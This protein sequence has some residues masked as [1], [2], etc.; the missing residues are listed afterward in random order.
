MLG[1]I[2]W[3]DVQAD[4][5]SR[6]SE[7]GTPEGAGQPAP[8]PTI[9]MASLS[10][11]ARSVTLSLNSA[12]AKTM[13]VKSI[14]T[15]KAAATKKTTAKK[16]TKKTTAKKKTTTKK[17]TTAK[18]KKTT[19]KKKTT[20]RKAVIKKVA[21][22]KSAAKK[23]VKIKT[24]RDEDPKV[25][26]ER[27]RL[28]A[29]IIKGGQP[30][31]ENARSFDENAQASGEQIFKAN[32]VIKAAISTSSGAGCTDLSSIKNGYIV[33]DDSGDNA[34]FGFI[35]DKT[36][37]AFSPANAYPPAG[38]STSFIGKAA[39]LFS[40]NYVGYVQL[41]SYDTR[42]CA[43]YCNANSDCV[44]F[45]IY[46]ERSPKWIANPLCNNPPPL[47]GI[48]CALWGDPID[49]STATN[50]G[51]YKID[52]MVVITAVNYLWPFTSLTDMLVQ[53]L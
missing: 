31:E 43:S 24:K 19:A 17:K 5:S 30:G 48:T 45:N 52:F 13:I 40:T 50:F 23:V 22:K 42:L 14:P 4:M 27:K 44:A 38:Y 32:P 53:W 9:D 25:A 21:A 1:G 6:F 18:K 33:P 35:V 26:A 49:D 12:H 41:P 3:A 28:D 8:T 16:T 15:T 51:Q 2:A 29:Q 11:V 46:A 37:A 47:T 10:S 39:G 20:P 7:F 36:L 34:G